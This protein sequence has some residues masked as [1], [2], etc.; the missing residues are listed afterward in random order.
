MVGSHSTRPTVLRMISRLADMGPV[1]VVDGGFMYNPFIVQAG[2]HGGMKAMN[3]ITVHRAFSCR[4]ML[5]ALESFDPGSA[6]FVILDF[7]NTFF[8]FFEAL[9]ERKSL[10]RLCLEQLNR[11]EQTCSGLVSVHVPSILSQTES[12]L[13]E[14]VTRACNDTYHMEMAVAAPTPVRV[15]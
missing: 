9:E 4:E 3:Q 11:F 13:L 1:R 14:M 8:Y 5:T 15:Y 2:T 7:L 6:P 10:L 12:E